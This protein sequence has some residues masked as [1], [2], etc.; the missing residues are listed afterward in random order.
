MTITPEFE[1]TVV[2]AHEI[3]EQPYAFLFHR[4]ADV[5]TLAQQFIILK[6]AYN[7]VE[8]DLYTLRTLVR[9]YAQTMSA[10]HVVVLQALAEKDL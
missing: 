6:N 9:E 3:I 7:L 8:E 10:T 1:Q 2:L 4:N 5:V